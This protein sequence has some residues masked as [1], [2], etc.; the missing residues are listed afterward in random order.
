MGEAVEVG[1]AEDI[2]GSNEVAEAC[3]PWEE[4]EGEG[5]RRLLAFWTKRHFSFI[6]SRL[7]LMESLNLITLI[8]RIMPDCTPQN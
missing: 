3:C 8:F 5:N 4:G 1:E 6:A 2:E 7:D